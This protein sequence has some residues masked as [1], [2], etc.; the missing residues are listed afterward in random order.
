MSLPTLLQDAKVNVL[1]NETCD[2]SYTETSDSGITIHYYRPTQMSC[3][4]HLGGHIDACQGDSG[5]PLVCLEES[6]SMNGHVNPV[7]RGVVSWGEGCA[8]PGKPGVYARMANYVD[9]IHETIRKNAVTTNNKCRKPM[10]VFNVRDNV[11]LD[12]SH[13]MCVVHCKDARE[14]PNLQE[15]SYKMFHHYFFKILP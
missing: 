8:R 10:E 2:T 15:E 5:G 13:E 12:C 1:A 4:G 6:A 7:L 11:I 9:W 14:V 3:F